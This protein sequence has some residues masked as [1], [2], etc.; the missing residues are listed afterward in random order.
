MAERS[1]WRA[2]GAAAATSCAAGA[3]ISMAGFGAVAAIAAVV[4]SSVVVGSLLVAVRHGLLARGLL[5][6]STESVL[7]GTR[8][9]LGAHGG[10]A[11]VAGLTRPEIFCD[12]ELTDALSDAELEAVTLHERAHQLARDPLRMTAVAAV[13]PLLS[14]L[15]PGRA[16]LARVAAR[17][18]I[19]ADRYAMDRGTSRAAIASALL[20]VSPVGPVHAAGFAGATD[21]RLRAL[22]GDAVVDERP[23]RRRW[24]LL[25]IA[26]GGAA[27]ALLLHPAAAVLNTICC[28]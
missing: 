9:Q 18:E 16:W 11:F 4:A 8:V 22:L 23:G 5:Q 28:P 7:A 1:P 20:K 27:C 19:A 15:A 21:L 12:R 13:A 6:R 26:V 10:A 25:G 3:A 2:A 14:R 24:I 17:R